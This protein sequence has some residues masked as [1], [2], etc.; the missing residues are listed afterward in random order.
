MEFC[1]EIQSAIEHGRIK[2]DVHEK[3]ME[4]DEHPFP[5][6]MVE[7]EEKG[8]DEGMK[9]LAFKWS[10]RSGAVDPKTQVSANQLGRQGRYDQ[11]EGSRRPH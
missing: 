11:E 5:A 8:A 1:K 10:K 2:F 4:I 3:P 7:G 6:N 9:V